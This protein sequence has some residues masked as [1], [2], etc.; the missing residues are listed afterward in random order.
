VDSTSDSSNMRAPRW[1]VS[2]CIQARNA[3]AAIDTA[4][5]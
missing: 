4:G 5:A 1:S 3:I 2:M